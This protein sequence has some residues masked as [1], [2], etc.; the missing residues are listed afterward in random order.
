MQALSQLSYGPTW[1]RGT[2]PERKPFVKKMKK[3]NELRAPNRPRLAQS[4]QRL[5]FAQNGQ[6]GVD[7]RRH[8][9][10]AHRQA[11]RLREFAERDAF[12]GGEIADDLVNDRCRPIGNLR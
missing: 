7:G 6:R 4:R 11:N 8:R 1:R 5:G 2:L 3:M 12:S 10:A 9:S